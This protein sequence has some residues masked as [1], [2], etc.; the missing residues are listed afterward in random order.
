[1]FFGLSLSCAPRQSLEQKV[2]CQ[3]PHVEWSMVNACEDDAKSNFKFPLT[4]F[5]KKIEGFDKLTHEQKLAVL[6]EE[7][8][9]FRYVY[10]ESEY[11]DDEFYR[12]PVSRDTENLDDYAESISEAEH[13]RCKYITENVGA[14]ERIARAVPYYDLYTNI[15]LHLKE[16]YKTDLKDIVIVSV[17]RGGRLPTEILSRALNIPEWYSLKIDQGSEELDVDKLEEFIKSGVFKGKHVLF[18]DSTVDSGR[19][20]NT[21]KKY[22][23]NDEYKNKL[24]FKDWSIVGSNENG[25]DLDGRHLNVNWGVDPDV[26]FEDN[27]DLMGVDYD[28]GSTTKTSECPSFSSR[29]IR[30]VLFSVP[31]GYYFDVTNDYIDR[32][33][34]E[35]NC[36]SPVVES[37]ILNI[38]RLVEIVAERVGWDDDEWSH[39]SDY[40]KRYYD[41]KVIT[42]EAFVNLPLPDDQKVRNQK[43]LIIGSTDQYVSQDIIQK[44]ADSFDSESCFFHV[45]TMDEAKNPGIFIRQVMGNDFEKHTYYNSRLQVNQYLDQTDRYRYY[46]I[47]SLESTDIDE[48]DECREK[49]VDESDSVLV[50]GGKKGTLFETLL[51]ISKG[52]QVF[53]IKGWGPVADYLESNPEIGKNSNLHICDTAEEALKMI[54]GLKKE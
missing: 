32:V 54:A 9:V 44:I 1:M 11:D 24:A 40:L 29:K 50:L 37:M 14:M 19:Q 31:D 39:I 13:R 12:I 7:N 48:A 46:F 17:D 22:F 30:E 26:T 23:E 41:V 3:Y 47:G 4:P 36:E 5:R 45:G 49:M 52:K 21:L 34:S 51:S 16:V 15:K 38:R 8:S 28:D 10:C 53:V 25:E 43:C 2:V 20:L 42:G 35:M 6:D 27:P 33:L 18:V